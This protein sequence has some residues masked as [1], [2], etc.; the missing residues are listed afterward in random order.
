[1]S[2]NPEKKKMKKMRRKIRERRTKGKER[3]L[4][5]ERLPTQFIKKNGLTIF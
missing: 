5:G 1:M 2:I 3:V 4:K